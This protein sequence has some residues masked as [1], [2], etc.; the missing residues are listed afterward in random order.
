MYS[1][2]ER[3][4]RRV[5]DP[6]TPAIKQRHRLIDLASALR[7]I[8][9]PKGQRHLES[10]RRR[11]V[12]DEFFLLQLALAL[13][14]DQRD[15]VASGVRQVGGEEWIGE[16]ER[17]LP[18]ELTQAQ[19][20][21]MFQVQED[22]ARERPMNRLVQGDVGSGKTAVALLAAL[23]SI[24]N[25]FQ[26]ALMVPTELLAEQHFLTLSRFLYPF[27]ARV[28]LMV[29][30]LKPERLLET[31]QATRSGEA[32]LVIGTHK[33][34]QE[35]TEFKRLGLV[36]VD[37]QHKFG[38]S[39]RGLLK[40]KGVSPDTLIMTAT[41][42]PRTLA[43]TL[44]GDLDI[45][46]LDES[47]PGR[48]LVTTIWVEPDRREE[49]YTLVREELERGNNA[50]VVYPVIEEGKSDL[51]GARSG[52][53]KML[54]LFSDYGVGLVHGQMESSERDRVIRG[55]REGKIRMLVSTTVIEVGI[56]IP[57]A[58]VMIVEHAERFGLSQLHQLRG[59]VGRSAIDS[60]CILI[61]ECR[62]EAAVDRLNALVE[63]ADGFQI[64][65]RDLAIR[66]PGEFFGTRQHG[67]PRLRIGNI[68]TD[69]EA[70]EEARHEASQ[71]VRTDPDLSHPEHQLLRGSLERY[72]YLGRSTH[73]VG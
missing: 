58:S 32:D 15:Q 18:F 45:S 55:F 4:G 71:L 43:L 12:F 51:A 14:R 24:R 70:M 5:P 31:Q 29:Q 40:A 21:V 2:L 42:I 59:R 47:P 72:Y 17:H 7:H 73:K 41:P 46:V 60:Y 48:G 68:A 3:Y 1:A 37:E 53:E 35:R 52:Y 8:H 56:D 39:Q 23:V 25:G 10:A 54:A 69:L 49:I 30:G 16:L 26:A 62:T 33:L 66:G 22:M 67:L 13:R 38:V 19:K 11:L 27:G 34:I 64:A 28:A 65:E 20:R 36:I 61:G 50:F 63:T 57:Q 44:Y 6:L 9:F